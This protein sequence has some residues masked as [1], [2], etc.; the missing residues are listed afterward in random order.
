MAGLYY[1]GKAPSVDRDLV[2]QVQAKGV[3]G[4]GVSRN[5]VMD[6]ITAKT[7]V[8]ITKK[9]V[10]EWDS[11]YSP[12]TY[13]QQ[14]DQLLLPIAAKGAV[15]GVASLTEEPA[16][17]KA[18]SSDYV[19]NS[20]QLPVLG[21]G[22]LRGPY[23]MNKQYGKGNIGGVPTL[24]GEWQYSPDSTNFV[25]PVTGYLLPFL[26]VAVQNTTGRTVLEV[27]VGTSKLY[28]DQKSIAMGYG[29]TWFEGYQMITVLPSAANR[30]NDL[31]FDATVPV[32]VYLWAFNEGG[33]RTNVVYSEGND[34]TTT[35]IAGMV[36]T[37]ALYV[38]RTEQ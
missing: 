16:L 38:A 24:I 2:T 34:G 30:T 22:T 3:F 19:I 17:S 29:R 11:G 21:A 27:R 15:G 37:S 32:Y 10:D 35:V 8:K 36:Y 18:G 28:A 13:Y 23:G 5:Y 6:Q 20:E 14:Q 25:M 26:Q 9:Q 12:V 4:T 33:G 1:V 31:V 7:A